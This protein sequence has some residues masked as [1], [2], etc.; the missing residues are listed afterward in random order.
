MVA[1]GLVSL[2][3]GCA[4]GREIT[5]ADIFLLTPT[6]DAGVAAPD[7]SAAPPGATE[8]TT[9]TA[10]PAPSAEAPSAEAPTSRAETQDGAPRPGAAAT[11]VQVDAGGAP[12]DVAD[13]GA[14]DASAPA[15]ELV[16]AG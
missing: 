2:A 3:V 1:A 7:A 8:A 9:E 16:D 14:G 12:S 4:K 6:A 11:A 13:T 10:T 15:D 5:E